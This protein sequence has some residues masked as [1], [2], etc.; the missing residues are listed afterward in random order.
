[1][2]LCP[3]RELARQTY[4]IVEYFCDALSDADYPRLRTLLCIGGQSMRDQEHILRSGIHML[5][6]TPGR[7]V[8]M[9]N[10]KKFTLDDCKYFVLDE[11][12]RL[13]DLGFEEE[14]RNIID[15]FH[16]QRQTLLFSATMPK[17][18]QVGNLG[19]FSLKFLCSNLQRVLWCNPSK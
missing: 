10:K 2:I 15:Y 18:I 12:D 4:E 19:E 8:D 16:H 9:L 14:I 7:L 1:M 3:S 13:I 11:A 17:Q 5:I 6:A